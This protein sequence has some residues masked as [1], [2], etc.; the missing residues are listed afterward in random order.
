MCTFYLK[1]LL[2]KQNMTAAELSRKSGI[3][4]GTISSIL[5]GRVTNPAIHTV[6]R[7]ANALNVPLDE[8]VDRNI[9]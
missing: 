7:L 5:S 9:K 4:K 1:D 8:L 2:K 3:D 6:V